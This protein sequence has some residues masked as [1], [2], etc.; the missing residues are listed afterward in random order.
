MMGALFDDIDFMIIAAHLFDEEEQ[1]AVRCGRRWAFNLN[2]TSDAFC[3]N[4]FRFR[5]DDLITLQHLLRIPDEVRL[6]NGSK[7]KGTEALCV[8]LRRLCYPCRYVDLYEMFGRCLSDI[9]RIVK[10]VSTHIMDNFSHLLDNIDKPWLDQH[11]LRT[12]AAA[13]QM[14][15]APLSNCWGFIDGTTVYICRPQVNQEYLFSGHKRQHCLKFQS[16]VSPNGLIVSLLGPYEGKRHDAGIFHESLIAQQLQE[17]VDENGV[18]FHVY[19]DSAYPLLDIVMTP[20]R[21][22]NITE[23]QQEFNTV[24]GPLRICVEWAFGDISRTFA[25]LDYKKNLKLYLQPVGLLYKVGA[26]LVN[27]RTCLYG[28]E[29]SKYFGIEPPSL[30]QYLA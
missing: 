12:M 21:G 24:M 27:C 29:T 28:N 13:V 11:S 9:S 10:W 6:C 26:I 1:A 18:P 20:Y 25:F 14:K 22:A 8:M 7:V 4:M 17:K 3:W 5:K 19:G 16:I 15:G 30:P 23:E 2:T